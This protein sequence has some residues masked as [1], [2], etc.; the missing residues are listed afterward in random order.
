MRNKAIVLIEPNACSPG[1]LMHNENPNHSTPAGIS[2]LATIKD[3]K[4]LVKWYIE[5]VV[6]AGVGKDDVIDVQ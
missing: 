6:N 4:E 2:A 1:D 5:Q 3:P